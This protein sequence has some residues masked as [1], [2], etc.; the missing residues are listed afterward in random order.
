MN[1]KT[2]HQHFSLQPGTKLVVRVLQDVVRTQT[3]TDY[4]DLAETLKC[5][6]AR[7]KIPYQWLVHDA[8]TQLERGG[9]TPLIARRAPRG[10]EA[11][12]SGRRLSPD[13]SKA[14]AARLSRELLARYR[15]AA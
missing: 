3:F 4:A 5:R 14:E 2:N 6:C 1:T 10:G 11:V 7:L 13:I 9:R 12:V 8:I 15:G